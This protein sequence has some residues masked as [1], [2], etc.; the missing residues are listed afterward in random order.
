MNRCLKCNRPLK[1]PFA[2]Y[3][4]ICLK[5]V[6]LEQQQFGDIYEY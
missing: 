1:D 6:L 4:P 5:K 3:G 2:K